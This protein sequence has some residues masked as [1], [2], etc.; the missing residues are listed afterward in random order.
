MG[1]LLDTN[2]CSQIIMQHADLLTQLA[3]HAEAEIA[4]CTI[5]QGEL[6]DM[7]GRSQQKEANLRLVRSFLDNIQ[8][9]PVTPA[10]ADLYGNLKAN[11]FNHFAPK[12]KD[13]RRRFKL[14]DLGFGDNDLWIAATALERNLI[15]ISRDS[16]FTRLQEVISFPLESWIP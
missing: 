3:Q 11:I 4:T 16:D 15:L 7:V 1:Y 6:I 10:I 9:H 8:V 5:V 14:K 2:H 13:Q 12:D